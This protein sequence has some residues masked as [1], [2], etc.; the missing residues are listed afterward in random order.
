VSSPWLPSR[1]AQLVCPY[2]TPDVTSGVTFGVTFRVTQS[3]S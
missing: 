1:V 3:L 2:Q